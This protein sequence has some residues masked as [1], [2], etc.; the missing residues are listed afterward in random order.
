MKIDDVTTT[1]ECISMRLPI[2]HDRQIRV[3][4]LL[5]AEFFLT[6]LFRFDLFFSSGIFFFGY[7]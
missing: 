1:T 3:L 4:A 2:P 7:S 5:S 6:F